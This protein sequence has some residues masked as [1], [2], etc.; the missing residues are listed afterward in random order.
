MIEV[1]R[2]LASPAEKLARLVEPESVAVMIKVLA[3]TCV[4]CERES[5]HDDRRRIASIATKQTIAIPQHGIEKALIEEWQLLE[6][7]AAIHVLHDE[8]L[9]ER[10]QRQHCAPIHDHHAAVPVLSRTCNVDADDARINAANRVDDLAFRCALAV[11]R[12]RRQAF[13]ERRRV[14]HVGHVGA[15]VDDD[16]D[17][18]VENLV[19]AALERVRKHVEL[20]E[21]RIAQIQSFERTYANKLF[22]LLLLWW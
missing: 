5:T 1:R 14:E 2:E 9:D 8:Q 4:P 13:V 7:L 3:V 20:C 10:F 18:D 12:Y 22:L 19:V 11:H 15:L 6:P 21:M 16:V 17:V